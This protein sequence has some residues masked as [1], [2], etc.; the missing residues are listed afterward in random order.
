MEAGNIHRQT[1]SEVWQ[2]SA[3]F[4]EMRDPDL[5]GG[6]CG[7][8]QFKTLCS[9]C[10]ARAYG[11]SGDYLAEEPFCAYDPASRTVQLS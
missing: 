5:L 10:R 11:M 3:L 6:K 7:V 8:C 1:F 4:G 9:G 2:G